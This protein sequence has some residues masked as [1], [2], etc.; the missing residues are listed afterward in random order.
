MRLNAVESI[1]SIMEIDSIIIYYSCCG[2]KPGLIMRYLIHEINLVAIHKSIK[3]ILT[4]KQISL[5]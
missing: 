4:T 5:Q 2:L 3:D 1:F